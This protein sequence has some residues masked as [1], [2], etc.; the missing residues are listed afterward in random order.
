MD[1][2][3]LFTCR[4]KKMTGSSASY[5]INVFRGGFTWFVYGY[6]ILNGNNVVDGLGGFDY[7]LFTI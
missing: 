2:R 1:L 7:E 4:W 5:E 6:H 3:F